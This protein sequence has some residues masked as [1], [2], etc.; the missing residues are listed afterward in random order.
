MSVTNI[1]TVIYVVSLGDELETAEQ[2]LTT[3][4]FR[5]TQRISVLCVVYKIH[6]NEFIK[7]DC[8]VPLCPKVFGH[9]SKALGHIL[10][11]LNQL[12][13]RKLKELLLTHFSS[14]IQ[15][16]K[17]PM[18]R[19]VRRHKNG[20]CYEIVGFRCD[21]PEFCHLIGCYTP[22]VGFAQTFRDYVLVRSSRI[23]MSKKNQGHL[24]P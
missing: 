9:L 21:L 15:C 5:F 18:L 16:P 24:D 4:Y 22:Q 1:L 6:I 2:Q 14:T 17:S 23:K 10:L 11:E 3:I 19:I 20:K 13:F 12:S 8:Q 7:T